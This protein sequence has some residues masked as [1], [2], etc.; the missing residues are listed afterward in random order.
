MKIPTTASPEV[1]EAFR[2]V[3]DALDRITGTQTDFKRVPL[4]NIG[5]PIQP[6]DAA[7]K[8]YVDDALLGR[9]S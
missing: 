6:F 5:A 7:T 8:A 1:Q 3:W 9:T 2:E 4:Q